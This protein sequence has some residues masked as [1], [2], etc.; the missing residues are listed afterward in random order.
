MVTEESSK[1]STLFQRQ[2]SIIKSLSVEKSKSF[3]NNFFN[4][5]FPCSSMCFNK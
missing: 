1:T 3:K 5:L 4:W 2:S